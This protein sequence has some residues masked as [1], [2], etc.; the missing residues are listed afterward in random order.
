ME[1]LIDFTHYS[2]EEAVEVFALRLAFH[3]IKTESMR[4]GSVSKYLISLG[5]TPNMWR[6]FIAKFI[7]LNWV[8]KDLPGDEYICL[9]QIHDLLKP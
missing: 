5:L 1:L 9:Q 7:G 6:P 3:T 4:F 8:L 2:D